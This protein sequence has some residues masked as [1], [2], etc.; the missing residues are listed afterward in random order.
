MSISSQRI[1]LYA[2]H[3]IPSSLQIEIG[4]LLDLCFPD[5]FEGRTYYKQ[6][7]H[8]RLLLWKAGELVGQLGVDS[9]VINIE[10]NVLGIFG[11]IDLCV[12]PREQGVGIASSLLSKVEEIGRL[13]HRDHLVL[14]A[15]R[16]DLYIRS[17]FNRVEPALTKWLAIDDRKSVSVIQRDMAGCF[18]IK[19]L[20]TQ[21][22]P[23]GEIDML[24]YL[25]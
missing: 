2:E 4:R 18:L 23:S 17:G 22:W 13:Y 7:P 10:G 25:F 9:R 19:P 6:L 14:M 12:H 20:S 15:D 3:E 5:T 24:G 16:H 1:Q 8:F 11:I 21:P